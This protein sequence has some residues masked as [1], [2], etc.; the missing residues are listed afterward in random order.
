MLECDEFEEKDALK[1]ITFEAFKTFHKILIKKLKM[2]I[3]WTILR[4]YGYDNELRIFSNIWDDESIPNEDLEEARAFE[5]KRD[6]LTFLATIFKTHSVAL[7]LIH[8]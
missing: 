5:L 4:Y 6:C 8:I 7:S 3:V 2:D 1:G